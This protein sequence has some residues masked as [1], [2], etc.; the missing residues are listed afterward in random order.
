MRIRKYGRELGK[1]KGILIRPADK[2]GGIVIVNKKDY[3]A[4]MICVLSDEATYKKLKGD[5]SNSFK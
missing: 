5:P 2:E 1:E 4:E 3:E